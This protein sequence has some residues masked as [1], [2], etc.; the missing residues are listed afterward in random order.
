[1]QATIFPDVGILQRT[2]ED[3]SE[4]EVF[5]QEGFILADLIT[6]LQQEG[7]EVEVCN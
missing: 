7:F 2:Y 3:G 4:T 6:D 5:L 1:M